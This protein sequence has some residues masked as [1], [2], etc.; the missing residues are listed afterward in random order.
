MR[1][2]LAL[3]SLGRLRRTGRRLFPRTLSQVVTGA[4]RAIVFLA[5]ATCAASLSAQCPAVGNDTACGFVITVTDGGTAI[6]ATGQPAYAPVTEGGD[7]SV[8]TLVG[9][10]N[11]SSTSISS[12]SLGSPLQIFYFTGFG[13]DTFGVQGNPYDTTGYG[14]PNAFFSDI[15]SLEQ[16]GTVNFLTP[17]APG[18]ETNFFSVANNLIA[19]TPCLN[20]INGAVAK[21]RTTGTNIV[22]TFTPNQGQTL[23]HAAATCGFT[24]F[25]WQ[26]LITN[27]P[28]PNTF[29]DT[30]FNNLTAPLPFNDPPPQGYTYQ[31]PKYN[32]VLLPVYFN[33]FAPP[34]FDLSLAFNQTAYT[35]R[36]SDNPADPCLYGS[37][38][39]TCG[40]TSPQGA[41]LSFSTHLVGVIGSDAN[42]TVQDTGIGFT[43][44]DD[45]NGTSGGAGVLNSIRPVDAGSGTG[46][47]TITGYNLRSTYIFPKSLKVTK[48][49]G[50]AAGPAL[51]A[52]LLTAPQVAISTSGL[53]YSR[54]TKSF[55]GTVTLTNKGPAAIAGPFQIVLLGLSQ[56]ATLTNAAGSF[57]GAPFLTL[58]GT[59]SLASGESVSIA[60]RFNNPSMAAIHFSPATYTGGYN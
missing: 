17:I 2:F 6:S 42:A 43:W 48:V 25:N 21:P 12:L 49:N 7:F 55:T 53:A 44:S 18:G 5:V 58:I 19:S 11:N 14:G 52:K 32:A 9:V 56:G 22:S 41:V 47:V 24:S 13:I 59:P 33:I 10:I 1:T 15:D 30:N 35:L 40:V 37:M 20:L 27:L 28:L 50:K 45:F 38:L 29:F 60:L 3:F 4:V 26:Q 31:S 39:N 8:G 46:G 36:F 51:T 57:A 16:N 54:A 23:S 34:D